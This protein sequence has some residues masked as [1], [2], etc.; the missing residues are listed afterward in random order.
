M[1]ALVFGIDTTTFADGKRGV[2]LLVSANAGFF[3]RSLQTRGSYTGYQ[4][5]QSLDD[6]IIISMITHHHY[7]VFTSSSS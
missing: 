5:L 7:D 3:Y 6:S 2:L 4:S 1:H